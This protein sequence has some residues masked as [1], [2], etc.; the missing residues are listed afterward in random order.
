MYGVNNSRSALPNRVL[1]RTLQS[2]L[3]LGSSDCRALLVL[4]NFS[5]ELH[6]EV[7]EECRCGLRAKAMQNW[8]PRCWEM[9]A[10]EEY[11]AKRAA[12]G[13]SRGQVRKGDHEVPLEEVRLSE[14]KKHRGT[15]RACV[16]AVAKPSEVAKTSGTP[17][18]LIVTR[19]AVGTR[20]LR[21]SR[22]SHESR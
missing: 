14:E 1:E 11:G 8:T 7:G 10:T 2:L 12:D 6:N 3:S 22:S 9:A 19:P 4:C 15:R 16:Q 18:S 13:R 17:N 5:H 20:A 21:T